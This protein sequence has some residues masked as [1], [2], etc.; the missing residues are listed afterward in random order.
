MSAALP[1]SGNSET[2]V[3][4]VRFWAA[5]RAAVGNATETVPVAAPVT[6][7]ALVDELVARHPAAGPVLQVCSVLLGDRPVRSVDPAGVLVEP[8]AT[9][10]FLPPFAGG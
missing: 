8:G 5:A 4:T 6:L 3:I 10:E 2:Q 9:V 1:D 7:A